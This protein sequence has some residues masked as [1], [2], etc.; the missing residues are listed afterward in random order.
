MTDS[1]IILAFIVVQVYK[2]FVEIGR[3]ALVNEG[4]DQGKL[5]VILD[6]IDQRRVRDDY[7]N[8]FGYMHSGEEEA[9]LL[10]A[11]IEK[12]ECPSVLC[13]PS[14]PPQYTVDNRPFLVKVGQT[15]FCHTVAACSTQSMQL[16]ATFYNS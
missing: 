1:I 2:R 3:V 12:N 8:G 15:H 10:L 5:C 16:L 13:T 7:F 14:S 11:L 4:P 6:V 9:E